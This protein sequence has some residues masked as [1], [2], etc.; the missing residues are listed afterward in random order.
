MHPDQLHVDADV[1]RTSIADQFPQWRGLDVTPVTGSGT[2]NA[3]FRLGDALTARFPLRKADAAV[4]RVE[5]EQEATALTEF[6]TVNPF[7]SPTPVAIGR[8]SATYPMP[9]SVQTW[10]EGEVATPVSLAASFAFARDLAEL[11]QELRAAPTRGRRFR[12]HGRGGDLRD[13]DEWVHVCLTEV[14]PMMDAEPLRSMWARFRSLP[15]GA[16]HVMSHGDLTPWNILVSGGRLRGILDAGWFGPADPS[17]DL[18]C[19]WHML[20]APARALLRELVAADDVEWER[21]AGWAFVQ[22]IGLVWYYRTSNPAMSWLGETTLRR[23]LT[24]E[25]LTTA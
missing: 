7:A 25:S 22:A 13:H 5:L 20:D 16:P 3:I 4:A 6:A 19:A 8:P 10:L 11:I 1:A 2:V 14:E 12:G 18:V 24:D 15:E 9:W 23:I 21:G 17:L